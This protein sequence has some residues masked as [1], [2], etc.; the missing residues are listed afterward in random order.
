MIYKLLLSFKGHDI[1]IKGN[2]PGLKRAKYRTSDWRNGSWTSGAGRIVPRDTFVTGAN[3]LQTNRQINTEAAPVLYGFSIFR[4]DCLKRLEHFV[5]DI[6]ANARYIQRIDFTG[7]ESHS[8]YFAT[9]KLSILLKQVPDLKEFKVEVSDGDVNDARRFGEKMGMDLACLTVVPMQWHDA[10]R[11]QA[12]LT[13]SSDSTNCSGCA[14]MT[15]LRPWE[16][17]PCA[18]CPVDREELRRALQAS[19]TA[20]VKQGVPKPEDGRCP[21]CQSIHT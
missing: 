5:W 21:H 12:L 20:A 16:R 2:K 9:R 8:L 14:A 19:F 3:I 11:L 4:S 6:G 1:V 17:T 10:Q 13:Y 18:V 7:R 15:R